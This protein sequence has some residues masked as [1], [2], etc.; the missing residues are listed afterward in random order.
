[1]ISRRWGLSRPHASQR[2]LLETGADLVLCGHDH[3]EGVD[4]LDGRLVVSTAGTHSVRTRGGR[5]SGFNV[6]R[7]SP[8]EITVIHYIYDLARL[9]FRPGDK[10][11]F[12]RHRVAAQPVL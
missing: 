2:A 8:S 12:A 1:V 3:T 11:I 10:A 5:P 7:I 4:Q 6:I 9:T